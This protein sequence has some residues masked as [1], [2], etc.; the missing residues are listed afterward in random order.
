MQRLSIALHCTLRKYFR[1]AL[2]EG[3]IDVPRA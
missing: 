2:Q 1:D 3:N